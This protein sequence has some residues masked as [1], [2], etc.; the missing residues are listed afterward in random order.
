MI[1]L[2]YSQVFISNMYQSLGKHLNAE[3]NEDML[4]HM[5]L[6]SIRSYKK[7]FSEEYG[8]MVICCDEGS[9][10][11]K[12][13]FPYYKAHRK[14]DRDQSELDWNLIFTI[15]KKIRSDLEENFPYR[16]VYAYSAE[17]DD[18]ISVL[19]EKYGRILGTNEPI[20][21]LSGD[22]DFIQLHTYTNVR[23]YDPVGKRWITHNDPE[24]YK[25]EHIIKGD[26]GDGI[27]NILS[28]GDSFV[29]GIRQKTMTAKRLSEYTEKIKSEDFNGEWVQRYNRNKSIIDLSE[30]PENLKN[31]IL[32]KYNQEGGKGRSK[33]FNYF[34]KHKLKNLTEVINDF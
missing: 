33:L 15:F 3:L 1:L 22:H 16:V 26:R 29:S 28:Q 21:I 23:Q 32:N 27:P 17:A 19:C 9:S 34:I 11:R 10:W 20:L 5:V 24:L 7:K 6:N 8:E 4:R 12:S 30:V 13:A 31:S 14:R 18:V 2:D 25:I